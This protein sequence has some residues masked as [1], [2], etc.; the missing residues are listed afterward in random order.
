MLDE[1]HEDLDGQDPGDH[2]AYTLGCV[3]GHNVVMACLPAGKYGTE[4]AATVAK[5]MLRTFKSLRFGLLVGIGGGVPTNECDIRL[6]DVVVSQPSK[7][8]GGVL[9]YDV[10]KALP[11]ETF[12]RRGSLNRPPDVLLN[13]LSKLK[14]SHEMRDPKFVEYLDLMY[15]R[16]PRMR[17][18]YVHPGSQYDHLYETICPHG[19]EDGSCNLC[20]TPREIHRAS[21]PNDS[22]SVH[23]G[24][25]A[26]GRRVIAS[27]AER[28][29]LRA[30][31][32]IL[33]FETEAAG[34]MDTFPCLVIRGICDYADRHKRDLWQRYAAAGAAAYAKELLQTVQRKSVQET[35]KITIESEA[36]PI[37]KDEYIGYQMD[38]MSRTR[39]EMTKG[40]SHDRYAK[41]IF[42]RISAYDPGKVH[43]RLIRKR[44]TGSVEWFLKEPRFSAWLENTRHSIFWCTGTIGT[45]KTFLATGVVE[46]FQ[47]WSSE[48][49][50]ATLFFYCDTL[51]P[52]TT[53]ATYVLAS[54]IKQLLY[55]MFCVKK[56]LSMRLQQKLESVYSL[57]KPDPDAED[58]VDLC[59]EM[60]SEVSCT[61]VVVDGLD[62]ICESDIRCVLNLLERLANRGTLTHVFLSSRKELGH[63][64]TVPCAPDCSVHLYSQ[65]LEHSIRCYVEDKIS[66]EY[67]YSRPLT[68]DERV[69]ET[70]KQRLVHESNGM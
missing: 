18:E 59:S 39:M 4:T 51:D 67:K 10:G 31:A 52:M 1:E 50:N 35:S 12:E 20:E 54:L 38:L 7:Q 62:E 14:S 21:R 60:F 69:L 58:L 70:V 47:T 28:D 22:P 26:S 27:A 8:D 30:T 45:G 33:S 40:S 61:A 16:Y 53:R 29:R 19:R 36:L 17:K 15:K 44:Y 24:L 66:Y 57:H 6:G 43:R 48:T 55:Y 13:A 9:Q 5:D 42:H 68:Q 37:G 46:H 65:M 49:G 32:D 41:E 2:N 3:D 34:L 64:V 11:N 23:Y 63:N 56:C 25:I